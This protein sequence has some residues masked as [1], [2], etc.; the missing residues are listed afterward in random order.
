MSQLSNNRSLDLRLTGTR[1]ITGIDLG[2]R[3][4]D[5]RTGLYAAAVIA[6]ELETQS[7]GHEDSVNSSEV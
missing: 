7:A 6:A 2:E 5:G 3:P 1:S 4:L